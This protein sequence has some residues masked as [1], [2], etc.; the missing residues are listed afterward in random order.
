[1]GTTTEDFVT[2]SRRIGCKTGGIRSSVLSVAAQGTENPSAWLFLRGKSTAAQSGDLLAILRDVLLTA[3][4][5]NHERLRQIV[6]EEKSTQE[7]GLAPGGHRLATMRLKAH[8]SRADWVAEQMSGVTYL[9]FLHSLA[10]QIEHDWA[11]VSAGLEVVRTH[12]ISRANLYVNLTLDGASYRALQPALSDFLLQLPA[13]TASAAPW[14]PA[15][16]PAPEGLTF[17]AQVNYVAKGANLFGLGIK[18]HGS[19]LVVANMILTTW[20]W[21][22]IRVQGGAYFG[23]CNFDYRSGAFT[24][25]SYRDPN[26]LAT[27]DVYDQTADFLRELNLNADE[28]TKAIIGVIGEMDN[29][30]LPEAKGFT[31]LTRF[32]AGETEASR[33]QLRNEVLAT[34][35]A[36]VKAFAE[37]LDLVKQ[38]GQVVVLGS[39][40]AITTANAQR[41]LG[42]HVTKLL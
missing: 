35:V 23:L 21:E 4:L 27:I 8:L 11:S 13:N 40:Q 37:V 39:E 33:Q 30:Q 18:P 9:L 24:Y 3:N 31:S 28:V 19:I 6:L 14:V 38:N 1:M 7:A 10:D 26:L 20:L 29:Y 32:L 25:V 41:Q 16:A 2:L 17:P 15:I 22:R 34:T 36:D 12:L 42:L 5:D